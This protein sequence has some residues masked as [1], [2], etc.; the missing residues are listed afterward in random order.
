[1]ILFPLEEYCAVDPCDYF[2]A[3]EVVHLLGP[4]G[5]ECSISLHLDRNSCCERRKVSRKG[6]KNAKFPL[7]VLCDLRGFARKMGISQ[8]KLVMHEIELFLDSSEV[9]YGQGI[10]ML[11]RAPAPCGFHRARPT[12]HHPCNI[13]ACSRFHQRVPPVLDD[14]RPLLDRLRGLRP[15][16]HG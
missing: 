2:A 5:Q 9:R 6:A 7:V 14:L 13:A 16:V 8:Q 3:N 10:R 15:T 12:H 1:M 4:N 11:K